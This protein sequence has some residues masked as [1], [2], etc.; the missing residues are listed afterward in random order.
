MCPRR[1]RALCARARNEGRARSAG[2][3]LSRGQRNQEP[4]LIR[5]RDHVL[6]S[7]AAVAA[8]RGG[9]GLRGGLRGG[10]VEG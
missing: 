1:K 10:G 3:A 6:R 9:R 4:S 7:V 5:E 8:E 2:R